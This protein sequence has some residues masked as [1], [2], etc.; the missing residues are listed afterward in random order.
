MHNL[1]VEN[2][3]LFSGLSEDSSP[4][5]SLADSPEGL[6]GSGTGGI[7]VFATKTRELEHQEILVKEN[8]T[9]QVN[10]FST[11]LFWGRWKR[12]G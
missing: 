8:Q 2:Y 3:V 11:F 6:L 1:K 9:C 10:E 12:L 7:G 5:D 4:G